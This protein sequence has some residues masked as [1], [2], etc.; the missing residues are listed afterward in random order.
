MKN[1]KVASQNQELGNKINVA[2]REIERL[3]D[4]LKGKVD[5]I[6]SWKQR[7]AKQDSELGRYRNLEAEINGY[8]NKIANLAG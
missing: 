5:E 2:G 1:S 8:Q 3:N 6:E 4:A 7:V